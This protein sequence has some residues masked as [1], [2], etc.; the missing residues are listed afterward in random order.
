MKLLEEIRQT[1]F[2]ISN[3]KEFNEAALKIFRFQFD[4][5]NVLR[6]FS[7]LLKV[8]PAGIDHYLQ[9]PFLPVGLFKN[10]K[11]ITGI[12]GSF[13]KAFASSTTTGGLPSLHY[14]RELKIYIESFT[15]TFRLFYGDPNQYRFLALLPGYLERQDS[16]LVYMLDHL[17]NQTKANGSGFYLH[18]VQVLNDLLQEKASNKSKTILFGASYALLDFAEQFLPDLKNVLIM[19]T[20]GMKGRKKEMVRQELHEILCRSFNVEKI[21]S[22]YGMT[23]LL[24]QAYSSGDGIFRTPPWM[25]ILIRDINDPLH[26]LPAG[27]TGG[28]NIIDLANFHSCAF[29]ATQDL[30]RLNDD[31]SFEVLGRFDDSDVRGCNLLVV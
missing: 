12:D 5:A 23:E 18:N 29:L 11:I 4:T 14:I 15:K 20:G 25:K 9:V 10:H 2:Q 1:V 19:E 27:Q 21:H 31:G 30:G 6:E 16:S 8:D 26:Y 7:Q 28:I 3:E 22:E 24:S 17:I 13:E